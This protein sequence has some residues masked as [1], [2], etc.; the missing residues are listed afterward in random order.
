MTRSCLPSFLFFW[1]RP[2]SVDLGYCEPNLLP[3][4][5]ATAKTNVEGTRAPNDAYS[6]LNSVLEVFRN[7]DGG[8]IWLPRTGARLYE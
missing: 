8:G 7:P 5:D 1:D 6:I 3:E 2:Y 4:N